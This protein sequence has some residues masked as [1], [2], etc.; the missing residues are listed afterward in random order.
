MRIYII[1]RAVNGAI[2]K[3]LTRAAGS[4]SMSSINSLVV[5]KTSK[6]ITIMLKIN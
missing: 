2:I 1:S 6:V 3:W 5:K 4:D